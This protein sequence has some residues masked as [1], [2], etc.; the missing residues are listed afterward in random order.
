MPDFVD[1][2]SLGFGEFSIIIKGVFLEEEPD[3]VT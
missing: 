2:T 3:L 1:S